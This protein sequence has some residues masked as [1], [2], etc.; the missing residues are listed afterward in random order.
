MFTHRVAWELAT[1]EPVPSG[2]DVLHTCDNPPCARND[3]PGVYFIRGIYRP[4]FG[5][6]WLGTN[7]DNII[8]RVE[9]GR[10]WNRRPPP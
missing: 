10:S 6:L 4:R 7:L 5:H 2:M 1:G 3:E 8:D 9:K